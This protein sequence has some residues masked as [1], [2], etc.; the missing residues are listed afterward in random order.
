MQYTSCV[1]VTSMCA[2]I[3]GKVVAAQIGCKVLSNSEFCSFL[4]VDFV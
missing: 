3:E 4:G 2:E 1:A